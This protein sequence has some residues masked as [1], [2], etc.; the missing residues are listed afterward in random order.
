MGDGSRPRDVEMAVAPVAPKQ[1]VLRQNNRWR[2]READTLHTDN[3]ADG[4][5]MEGGDD[6]HCQV[7]QVKSQTGKA[8]VSGLSSNTH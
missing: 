6:E 4:L 2:Q 8:T 5:E 3:H 7:H 1:R